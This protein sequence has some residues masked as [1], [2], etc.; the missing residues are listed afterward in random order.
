L[1]AN[2]LTPADADRSKGLDV[3][4]CQLFD[5]MFPGVLTGAGDPQLKKLATEWV[6]SLRH[7]PVESTAFGAAAAGLLTARLDGDEERARAAALYLR[8]E[9]V[10][11]GELKPLGVYEKLDRS[12]AFRLLR[13]MCQLLQRSGL[14]SGTVL[15]FD[16]ARR[17]LSLMSSKGQKQ[18]CEN[19]LNVINRC[20]SG[21]LPGTMFVYAVLPEFFTNFATN[22]PALQ[23]RCG[24]STRYSLETL[25]NIQETDLQRQI[26]ERIT[27]VFA[28]AYDDA[29]KDKLLLDANLRLVVAAAMKQH[30]GTGPRRLLVKGWVQVLRGMR[31]GRF[32]HLTADGVERL[33][34][35]VSQAQV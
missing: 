27:E 19:L 16:E 13:S 21:E 7:V 9:P 20:N 35:G 32:N 6:A 28:V 5:R 4:L 22:Y 8:G 12:S 18:A 33:L 29:P 3:V 23:Q 15:L 26:G 25:A 14:A 24:P 10:P 11:A 2:P 31:D 34:A 30:S 1:Q 17:S